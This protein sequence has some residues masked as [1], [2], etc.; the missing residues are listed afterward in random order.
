MTGLSQTNES[1]STF[2][3]EGLIWRGVAGAAIADYMDSLQFPPQSARA[4]GKQL[5]DFIRQQA[6]KD[7]SELSDWTV[8]F[9]SI[10]EDSIH[11][12]KVQ[13]KTV[14]GFD[15]GLARRAAEQQTNDSFGV[16]K[17]N[18]LSPADEGWDFRGQRFDTVWLDA[19]SAKPE[20]SEDLEWLQNQVGADDAWLLAL[21]L[22]K[23]WQSGEHPRLKPP[24]DGET[25]RPNGRILRMLRPKS[26]ALLLIY[27]VEPPTEVKGEGG[28]PDIS[29]GMER[30][31]TPIVAVALSFPTSDTAQGVEYR[32]NR[33]WG[34]EMQED[35]AY[36]D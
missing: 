32:V 34:A 14:A 6:A 22:T 1:V 12:E 25:K 5:A 13:I 19:I 3:G 20:L 9:V 23:R 36:D 10:A 17:A 28:T 7:G 8:V 31:G 29:T 11:R 24:K 4:S 26:R 27:P 18:I 16:R 30:T 33:V 35:A 15:V 21:E 2:L